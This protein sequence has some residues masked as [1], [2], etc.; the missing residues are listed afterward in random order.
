[1]CVL[2]HGTGEVG[3]GRLVEYVLAHSVNMG[4]GGGGGGEEEVE[5]VCAN[6]LSEHGVGKRGGGEG[7]RVCVCKLTQ[8]SLFPVAYHTRCT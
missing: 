6:S 3:G 4:G 2:I 1:M 5:C 7:G 8:W